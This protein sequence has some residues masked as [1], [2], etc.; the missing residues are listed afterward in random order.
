MERL[1]IRNSDGSVSQPTSTTIQ[2][3]FEK[4]AAYE[5]LEEQGRLVVLPCKVGDTVYTFYNGKNC[6]WPT[7]MKR[8]KIYETLVSGIRLHD[9]DADDWRL[10]LLFDTR[11]ASGCYE[12][13]FSE[14]GKTVF[15]TRAEVEKAMEVSE[16][17]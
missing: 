3:V 10:L 11:E 5:D 13:S 7:N 2:A 14:V 4:L 17:A 15:L 12:F 9:W 16:D 8:R 6:K 1:T